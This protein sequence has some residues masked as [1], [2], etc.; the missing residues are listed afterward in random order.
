MYVSPKGLLYQ[1]PNSELKMF[2][3]CEETGKT[4]AE[5]CTEQLRNI[6]PSIQQGMMG[7]FP[8]DEET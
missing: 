5:K 7:N 1:N 8:N 3:I 6:N 2:K 4:S